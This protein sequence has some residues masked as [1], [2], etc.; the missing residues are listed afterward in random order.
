MLDDYND[1]MLKDDDM[2]I[3]FRPNIT[4]NK[5][6]DKTVDVNGLIM[7]KNILNKAEQEELRDIMY[8]LVL[9][10]NLLNTDPDFSKRISDELDRVGEEE[11]GKTFENTITTLSTWTKTVGNA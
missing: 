10:F 8:A 11:F 9:C 2:A 3:I 5:I 4:K 6:W 1:S 7:P